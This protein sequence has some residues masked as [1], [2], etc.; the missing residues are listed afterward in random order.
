MS[1]FEVGDTRDEADTSLQAQPVEDRRD[2][3]VV[4]EAAHH[5]EMGVVP[6]G[7]HLGERLE[8]RHEPLHGDVGARRG[9]ESPRQP[10]NLRMG[11]EGRL[12]DPDRDDRQAGEVDP[13][14]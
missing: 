5:D 11:P 13:K 1:Q 6:L 4:A 8:E 14:L 7:P 3:A 12:V 2:P 9:D 10:P